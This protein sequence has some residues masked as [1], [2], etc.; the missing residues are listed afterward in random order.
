MS[1]I[2]GIFPFRDLKIQKS[3]TLPTIRNVIDHGQDQKGKV[4]Y[5]KNKTLI[6]TSVK[7]FVTN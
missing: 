1:E 5:L 4:R 7:L 2:L 3:N 6:I